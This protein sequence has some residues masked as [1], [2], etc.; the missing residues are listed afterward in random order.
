MGREEDGRV[1]GELKNR[2]MESG[3]EEAQRVELEESTRRR[4]P[5]G[6]RERSRW[7]CLHATGPL[8]SV[9]SIP[10]GSVSSLGPQGTV[11]PP[12]M[13]QTESQTFCL[14]SI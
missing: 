1:G 6:S 13:P 5:S 4:P 12:K 2:L 11:F 10:T 14:Q 8:M 3:S 7:I 9:F